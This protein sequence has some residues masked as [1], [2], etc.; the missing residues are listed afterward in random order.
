MEYDVLLLGDPADR[1]KPVH[2]TM[3]KRFVG[4]DFE[5]SEELVAGAQ[6]DRQR[7]YVD[8][9]LDWRVTGDE[10]ELLVQWRG[11]DP[12]WEPLERL[13]E[14]VPPQVMKFLRENEEG[15]EELAA[16]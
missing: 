16:A 3:M 11:F 13:H 10:M 4:P 14:D 8:D 9:I 6:H 1:K 5:R 15:N 12:T 7:F 2:W